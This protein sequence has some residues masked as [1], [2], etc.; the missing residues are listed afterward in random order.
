[1]TQRIG[2]FFKYDSKKCFFFFKKKTQSIELF[3]VLEWNFFLPYESKNW[4][5]LNMTHRIEL[6]FWIWLTELN[7]FYN[8]SKNWT[9]SFWVRLKNWTLF[10]IWLKELNFFIYK[11]RTMTQRSELEVF[12]FFKQKLWLKEFNLFVFSK[13]KNM[14]QRIEPFLFFQ[15]KK[16]NS[17]NWFFWYDSKNFQNMTLRTELFFFF[18]MR[19]QKLNFLAE[20][21]S[22]NWTLFI[23]SLRIEPLFLIR[24]QELNL[25]LTRLKNFVL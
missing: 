24:L 17:R 4:I 2:P 10:L 14:T 15:K 6:F 19:L 5:F 20:R 13:K 22:K 9:L 8:D 18:Q 12:V 3:W 11:K 23:M 1:M 16:Q 25:S 7:L 21:Y